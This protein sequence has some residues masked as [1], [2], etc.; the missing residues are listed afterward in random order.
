MMETVLGAM[1]LAVLLVLW[2]AFLSEPVTNW[3]GKATRLSRWARQERIKERVLASGGAYLVTIFAWLFTVLVFLFG[4]A[5]TLAPPAN[6][7]RNT[8]VVMLVCSVGLGIVA[9]WLTSRWWRASTS[10][11]P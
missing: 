9:S 10:K 6:S 4:L 1:G 5:M 11:L 7:G 2:Q 3:V 8:G